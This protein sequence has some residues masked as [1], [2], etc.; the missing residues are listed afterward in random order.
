MSGL[1]WTDEQVALLVKLWSD[2]RLSASQC[3]KVMKVTRNAVIGKVHRLH[4]PSRRPAK[5]GKPGSI[6]KPRKH[7]YLS[8]R[9]RVAL[10]MPLKDPPKIKVVKPE[11]K[12]PE[13]P[14]WTALPGTVPVSL[15]NLEVG[16]CKW[17]IGEDSPYLFCGCTAANGHYCLE[18]YRW[19]IG[20]GTRG[21]QKA[22]EDARLAVH[23]ERKPSV[24]GALLETELT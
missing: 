21:E 23:F 5:P 19:S 15:V 24:L 22:A 4:L 8:V 11:P 1:A 17:P 18:H 16:M 14:A 3:A 20:G 7:H 13:Q 12:R 10:K 2:D 6:P 9:R